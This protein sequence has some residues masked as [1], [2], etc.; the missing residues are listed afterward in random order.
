MHETCTSKNERVNGP[1][2]YGHP[3]LIPGED[4]E[5]T[6]PEPHIWRGID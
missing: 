5:D 4:E 2:P 3:P 6:E 1:E